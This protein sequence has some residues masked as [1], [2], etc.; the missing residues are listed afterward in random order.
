M[1]KSGKGGRDYNLS[2]GEVETEGS[3][4]LTPW[5][6]NLAYYVNSRSM[7]ENVS[8]TKM[9]RN[10]RNNPGGCTLASIHTYLCTSRRMRSHIPMDF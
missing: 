5:P 6:V 2:V 7:R 10:R 8:K 9:D 3:P 1:R 4:G